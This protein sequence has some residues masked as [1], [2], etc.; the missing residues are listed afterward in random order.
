ML[1]HENFPE[2]SVVNSLISK[3]ST[4]FLLLFPLENGVTFSKWRNIPS[5]G[6]SKLFTDP[7]FP[8][9]PD[10]SKKIGR[11]SIRPNQ[12]DRYGVRLT[13]YY[14]VRCCLLLQL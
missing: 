6:L 2:I 7:R 14:V 11:L 3:P 13:T 1:P 8:N 5:R 4:L 9:K 10:T 12:G